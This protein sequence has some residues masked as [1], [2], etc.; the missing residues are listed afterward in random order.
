VGSEG[1]DVRRADAGRAGGGGQQQAQPQPMPEQPRGP[2]MTQEQIIRK[3]LLI[4]DPATYY[5]L[6]GAPQGV[7]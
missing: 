6:Y 2:V 3:W 7:M 4:N 1:D 5:R